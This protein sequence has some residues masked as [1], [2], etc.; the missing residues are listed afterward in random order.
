M[1]ATFLGVQEVSE[2]LF[3]AVFV[4]SRNLSSLTIS[5]S[6]APH[7]HLGAGY[8]QTLLIRTLRGSSKVYMLHVSRYLRQKYMYYCTEDL[9]NKTV[10]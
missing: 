1:L 5:I 10:H 9:R 4:V 8:S 2:T 7:F 6:S 3:P